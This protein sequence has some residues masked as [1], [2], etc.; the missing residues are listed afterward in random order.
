MWFCIHLKTPTA[1][2]VC[3]FHGK[4]LRFVKQP[5]GTTVHFGYPAENTNWSWVAQYTQIHIHCRYMRVWLVQ[6]GIP[7]S[8]RSNT[9]KKMINQSISARIN[10][11]TDIEKFFLYID[12][13][14]V[15]TA[16]QGSYSQKCVAIYTCNSCKAMADLRYETL[17]GGW[18]LPLWKIWLK[19]T[20]DFLFHSFFIP[21]PVS[22]K[23][24]QSCSSHHQHHY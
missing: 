3:L 14:W 19:V 23:I 18:T 10:R 1:P 22:G 21:S 4:P 6:N 17:V 7:H 16:S 15:F 12:V 24:I 8:G 2:P 11:E 20:W 5:V 9:K 13:S